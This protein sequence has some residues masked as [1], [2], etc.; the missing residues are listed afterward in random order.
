MSDRIA[1]ALFGTAGVLFFGYWAIVFAGW[2]EATITP[3][4]LAKAVAALPGL[5]ASLVCGLIAI[6]AVRVAT[7]RPV[8]SWWLALAL[9]LP[10][11][12]FGT[13]ALAG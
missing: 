2:A 5:A 7:R 12:R 13:L 9:V 6:T 1:A 11:W 8:I 3:P 10:L 4:G